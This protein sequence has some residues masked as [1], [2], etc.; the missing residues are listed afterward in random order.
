MKFSRAG[1]AGLAALLA[2]AAIGGN[3]WWHK[4]QTGQTLQ[5][6]L[7]SLPDLQAFPAE[8][9]DRLRSVAT[10]VHTGPQP[11][12]ALAELA[13]LYQAN[14]F[15]AEAD[16]AYE[17][18]ERA[19]PQNPRWPH[20]H[21][22]MLASYGR[23]EEA[24]PLLRRVVTLAP[25][26]I[27]A[28]LRLADVLQKHNEPDEARK[29]SAG[30]LAREPANAY[31]QT[32][33]KGGENSLELSDPWFDELMGDCYD[34]YRL[35]VVA[36]AA[37]KAGNRRTARTL[38]ERALVVR[39][40]FALA[41]QQLGV[42][43]TSTGELTEARQH[44]ERAVAL[45]PGEPDNWAYLVR[46]LIQ[47]GDMAEA[48]RTLDRGIAVCPDAPGLHNRRAVRLT[49][50]RRYDEAIAEYRETIRLRPH[51]ATARLELANLYLNLNRIQEGVEEVHRALV[52]EPDHP[53]AL[54]LLT[55]HA[56]KSGNEAE[57]TEW[58]RTM[59][60]QPR[61]LPEDIDPLAG[62]FQKRFG[63]LPTQ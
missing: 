45:V 36:A 56:I 14:D 18:L 12:A 2:M 16:R 34:A 63:H 51:E 23:L 5:S 7:S 19:D 31:A 30:V 25:D 26:Y 9:A 44:L 47:A 10:R 62:D 54:I 1:W 37:D 8:L 11:L 21:A 59:R 6:G 52:A 24:L 20:L 32:Q 46:V 55:S 17:A 50:T 38:L 22:S 42:L 57:A 15:V 40:D 3:R 58:F 41:H 43:L 13:R 4:F 28:Q 48:D 61:L 33:L 35:T 53:Y 39:P 49:E 27:P 60:R 29:V